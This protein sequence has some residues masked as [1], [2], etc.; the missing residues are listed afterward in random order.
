MH[1][2]KIYTYINF[3]QNRVS[4]SVKTV[5]TNLFAK[6]GKLHKFATCNSNFKKSRLSNMHYPIT[7][8][9][10]D[11][12]I[13]RPIRYQITT[14]R[15]YFHRQQKDKQTD[16]QTLNLLGRFFPKK[17]ILMY[18]QKMASCIN[19][20]LSIVILKKSILLD[21]HHRKTYMYI[22][23]QQNQVSRSVKTVQ[24]NLFAKCCKFHKFATC[25]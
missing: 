24:A 16:G 3:H 21:M 5:H 11:F 17:K 13:N 20:Q 1:H 19:L 2:R 4:R 22:N 12:E 8:I 9:H 15:K 7:D 14:K 23:F 18:L 25:N 6:N 10:A